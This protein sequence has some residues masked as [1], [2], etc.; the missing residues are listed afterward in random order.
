MSQN[1]W[2]N[3]QNHVLKELE[4][5][6]E[7]QK[8]LTDTLADFRREMTEERACQQAETAEHKVKVEAALSAHNAKI[9][10]HTW[11]IR[12][13]AGAAIL[14]ALTGVFGAANSCTNRNAIQQEHSSSLNLDRANRGRHQRR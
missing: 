5:L 1:G 11:F 2:N 14:A 8:E 13:V 9:N 10:G 3:W 4:R 7:S 12:L 6:N